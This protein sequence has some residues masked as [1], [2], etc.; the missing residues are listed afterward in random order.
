MHE[1]GGQRSRHGD[2]VLNV[3]RNRAGQP[4]VD[5]KWVERHRSFLSQIVI[6]YWY[7][8]SHGVEQRLMPEDPGGDLRIQHVVSG[9]FRTNSLGCRN[10]D[11]RRIAPYLDRIRLRDD[12]LPFGGLPKRILLFGAGLGAPKLVRTHG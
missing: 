1:V 7:G 6:K 4:C 11:E 3:C 5:G 10:Q 8:R 2:W 9:W 12:V